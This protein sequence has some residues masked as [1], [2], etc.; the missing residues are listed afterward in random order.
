MISL[1]ITTIAI[2]F[3]GAIGSLCLQRDHELAHMMSS[4]SSIIAALLALIFSSYVLLTKTIFETTFAT[5]FPL[6]TISFHIDQLSALFIFIIALIGLPVSFYGIGYM[7]PYYGK[8]HMGLFGFF[9][10]FFLLSLFLVVDR[11]SVV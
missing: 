11:K 8:Y 9:Y 3:I 5:S 6:F 1:F 10:N 4:V 7:K 2:L